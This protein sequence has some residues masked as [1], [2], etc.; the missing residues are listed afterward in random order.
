[1]KLQPSAARQSQVQGEAQSQ[2]APLGGGTGQSLGARR[3]MEGECWGL[4]HAGNPNP[5]GGCQGERGESLLLSGA[6][7]FPL[8]EP[9]HAAPACAQRAAGGAWFCQS[10][11]GRREGSSCSC[12]PCRQHA[13]ASALP[14]SAVSSSLPLPS[15]GLGQREAAALHTQPEL[16]LWY[17]TIGTFRLVFPDTGRC[18]KYCHNPVAYR[19]SCR[20]LSGACPMLAFP[21]SPRARSAAETR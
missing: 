17:I 19:G 15:L 20:A 2:V 6:P 11:R 12:L 5:A 18:L 21:P 10:C 16:L 9:A 7:R 13:E 3:R 14:G 8:R 1:M 4:V